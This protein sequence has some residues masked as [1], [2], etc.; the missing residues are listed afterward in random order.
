MRSPHA[1]INALTIR[2]DHAEACW[3]LI[4]ATARPMLFVV[5]VCASWIAGPVLLSL[6]AGTP[7]LV[8]AQ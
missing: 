3:R 2:H 7:L 6:C 1:S 8:L 4:A 5:I